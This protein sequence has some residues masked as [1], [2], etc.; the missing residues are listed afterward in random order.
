MDGPAGS[1]KT[2]T[3][4]Y[5]IAE[6][7]SRGFKS[8]TAALTGIVATLLTIGS[9]L[10]GLFKPPVPILDNSTCNVTHKSIHGDFLRLVT[11]LL[12]DET[13]M[14][15]IHDLNAINRLLK[16]ICNNNFPFGG[17]IILFGGDFRQILH[18]V[19]RGQPAE[20]VESC[21]K[22]SLHWQWVQKFTLTENMRVQNGE[23]EFFQ[24]LQKLGNGT[25]PVKEKD[26]FKGCIE[27]PN[28]RIIRENQS[29]YE[30]IFGDADQNDYSKRVVLTPTNVDSLSI[31]K[32]VLECLPGEGKIYLSADRINTDDLNERNFLLSF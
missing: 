20:I 4:N 16:D 5:L 1:R 8:A 31:N 7:I 15:P 2:F 10:H 21:I 28:Q 6:T 14:I 11:L 32:E 22:C 26:P 27:L 18:V 24:W 23:G 25:I 19:K 12:L 13:S 30:K 3:N 29:I 17:K 9:T